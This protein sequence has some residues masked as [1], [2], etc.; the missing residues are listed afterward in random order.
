MPLLRSTEARAEVVRLLD[1]VAP[2]NGL[3]FLQPVDGSAGGRVQ[4][5]VEDLAAAVRERGGDVA[6]LKAPTEGRLAAWIEERARERGIRL[7]QGAAREL[8]TRLGGFVRE[9]D[10]DRRRIGQLAVGEL[11][12]LALYRPEAEVSADDVRALVAEAIP[13]S[14]WAF[15]DAVGDRHLA[16]AAARLPAILDTLNE[17][18]IVA[19]LHRRLRELI[20]VADHLAEGAT[21]A[22]LVRILGQKPFRVEKLVEQAR[23]WT[24]P[25]L[26]AALEGL[27]AIDE[28]IKG[29]EGSSEA[30]RRLAFTLW[31]AE[32]VGPPRAGARSADRPGE[33]P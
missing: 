16:N 31:L 2:G 10:V 15:L 8:G 21:P 6:E 25:E 11:E 14:S 19:Q 32:S 27:A 28:R 4:K 24:L 23:R 3:V 20:E 18:V 9:G 26:Q 13:A 33:R 22:S 7:G 5:A 1:G 29:V 12:K 17:N 30:Q